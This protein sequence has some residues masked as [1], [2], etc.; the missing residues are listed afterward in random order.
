MIVLK[1]IS[2]SYNDGIDY[3]VK[4]LSLTVPEGSTTVLL[5][6]S[7]CGKTTLLKMIA[8]LEEP[9]HGTIEVD[10]EDISE[11]GLVALRRR[12]GM[13]FQQ[14]G[15]FPH[16]SVADNIS[17]ILRLEKQPKDYINERVITLL[18][19]VGMNHVE[20]AHRY[21]HELSGGQ[22][23]RIGVARALACKPRYLLMDEPFAALDNITRRQMQQEMKYIRDKTGV[24]V[25]F[26]THDIFEAMT[27]G[28]TIAVMEHGRIEQV[29]S[30]E[31]ILSNPETPFVKDL[32][33]KPIQEIGTLLRQTG[34]GVS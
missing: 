33:A 24:T 19:M 11:Q 27:V 1:H 7:G 3:V 10:G 34:D 12:I 5:G 30:G 25:I 17:L 9:S 22:Q 14:P 32:I 29:G 15:L 31:D 26:V 23:Q 21:P 4:D 8:R 6:S 2:K 28:D 13:V 16:M 18:D 20:Y